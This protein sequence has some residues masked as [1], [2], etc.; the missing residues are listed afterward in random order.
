MFDIL[1]WVWLHTGL[2]VCEHLGQTL[3]NTNMRLDSILFGLHCV[4]P[5]L[6]AIV[7]AS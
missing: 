3:A 6:V 7:S 4:S 5:D 1:T 2:W